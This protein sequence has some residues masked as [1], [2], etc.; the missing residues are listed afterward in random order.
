MSKPPQRRARVQIDVAPG[1]DLLSSLLD[2]RI[3]SRLL[4]TAHDTMS[5]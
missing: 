2:G 5:L 4:A 3:Y 1:Q